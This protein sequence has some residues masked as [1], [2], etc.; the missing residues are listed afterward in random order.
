MA[1]ESHYLPLAAN[2]GSQRGPTLWLHKVTCQPPLSCIFIHCSPFH[3][4]PQGLSGSV[5]KLLMISFRSWFLVDLG[6]WRER[7]HGPFLHSFPPADLL[8]GPT[9]PET[10][11]APTSNRAGFECAP[12]YQPSATSMSNRATRMEHRAHGGKIITGNGKS[13]YQ[14][15]L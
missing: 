2:E 7:H 4:E 13:G 12:V 15:F 3:T 11:P 6:G 1:Q 5:E 8:P 14:R 9:A 10:E